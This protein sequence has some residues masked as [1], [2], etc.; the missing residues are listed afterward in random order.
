MERILHGVTE[1]QGATYRLRLRG[2]LR[3]RGQRPGGAAARAELGDDALINIEPIMAGEDFSAY[4][5]RAPGAFF[6]SAPGTKGDPAPPSAVHN[7]RNALRSG[8]A[9]FT[10]TALDYL[11]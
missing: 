5:T 1:A 11:A 10:R 2:G 4:L 3:P 9:V 8:V 7:R 6:G